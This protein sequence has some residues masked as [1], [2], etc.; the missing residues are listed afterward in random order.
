MQIINLPNHS[1]ESN[2][3]LP[4]FKKSDKEVSFHKDLYAQLHL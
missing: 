1:K 2:N 4:T 3:S